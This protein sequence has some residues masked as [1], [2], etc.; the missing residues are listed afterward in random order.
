MAA[1]TGA[2][3]FAPFDASKRKSSGMTTPTSA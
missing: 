3:G 1:M 2:R